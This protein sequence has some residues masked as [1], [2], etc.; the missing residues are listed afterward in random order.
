MKISHG[1]RLGHPSSYPGTPSSKSFATPKRYK[2]D[3]C[4]KTFTRLDSLT[5]HLK[6]H[7]QKSLHVCKVCQKSFQ[8]KS[9]LNSHAKTHDKHKC[10]ICRESFETN[11][12][13]ASHQ[14]FH[15]VS[16]SHKCDVCEKVFTCSSHLKRHSIIHTRA[17][18]KPLSKES[19]SFSLQGNAKK[20][21][22]VKLC[23]KFCLKQFQ[24]E[25]WFQNHVQK[26]VKK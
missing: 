13:L 12:K 20:P 4:S 5:Q 21:A 6:I 3:K 14:T 10:K 16:R 2:C 8:T 1:P 15:I 18:A 19:K 7:V 11:K 26:C 17:K 24:V 22:K 23:C 25:K 9:Q